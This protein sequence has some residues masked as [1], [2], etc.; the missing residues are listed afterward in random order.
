MIRVILFIS[1]RHKEN[2][3][4]INLTYKNV[5][6]VFNWGSRVYHPERTVFLWGNLCFRNYICVIQLSLLCDTLCS[7]SGPKLCLNCTENKAKFVHDKGEFHGE[8]WSHTCWWSRAW[9]SPGEGEQS[10]NSKLQRE[11]IHYKYSYFSGWSVCCRRAMSPE[12]KWNQQNCSKMPTNLRLCPQV[13]WN[14]EGTQSYECMGMK[15]N[16]TDTER[17]T[18]PV[19]ATFTQ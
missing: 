14:G 6:H 18:S 9:T 7:N 13:N 2:G 5:R 3:C 12:L 11:H 10:C 1:L 4:W 17:F 8:V 15:L 19:Y 16:R